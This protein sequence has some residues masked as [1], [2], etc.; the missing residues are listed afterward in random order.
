MLDLPSE[1]EHRQNQNNGDTPD[2][3]R[4]LDTALAPFTKGWSRPT[5]FRVFSHE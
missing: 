2:N 5:F 3:Q 4:V 1:E